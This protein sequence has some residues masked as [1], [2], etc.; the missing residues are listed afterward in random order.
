MQRERTLAAAA[1][2]VATVAVATAALV[3]GAIADPTEEGP[4]RPGP[5]ELVEL[6][7]SQTDVT[8][9]TVTLR[10][11]AHLAHRGN[12]TRNVTVRFR[13]VDGDS[14]LV[15][16]TRTVGVGDLTGDRE[17]TATANLTVER[18][19]DYRIEAAVFADG[20]RRASGSRTVRGLGSLTPPYARSTPPG[21]RRRP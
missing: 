8:G 9:E 7:I 3:P 14:G 11:D 13:A 4:V 16:T 2:V 21:R 5:V 10:V 19:G 12:P 6:P 18:A 20:E 17:T 15:A 1:A